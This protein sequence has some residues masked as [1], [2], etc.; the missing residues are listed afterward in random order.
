MVFIKKSLGLFILLWGLLGLCSTPLRPMTQ[1]TIAQS[2]PSA[3][4]KSATTL[5]QQPWV[6]SYFLN[7]NHQP[8]QDF[9]FSLIFVAPYNPTLRALLN[10][11]VLSPTETHLIHNP[12]YFRHLDENLKFFY[13]E[14]LYR[15]TC[16]IVQHQKDFLAQGY[17][18]F[19]H[20]QH[21]QY[22]LF[23]RWYTKLWALKHNTIITDFLFLHVRPHES[24]SAEDQRLHAHL[25][26]NGRTDDYARKHLLFMNYALFANSANHGSNTPHYIIKN[27]NVRPPSLDFKTVFTSIDP[28]W[29][30]LYDTFKKELEA[31]AQKH[32]Q[33]SNY[34]T[35]MLIAIP[36][37]C[38]EQC[39]YLAAGGGYKK[40]LIIAGHGDTENIKLIMKTLSSNPEN[41]SESD[42][43]EFC[44][45]MTNSWGLN[46]HSGIKIIEIPPADPETLQLFEQ[47]EKIVFDKIMRELTR[48]YLS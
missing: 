15:L 33:L 6:Q 35:L 2:A 26:Q 1:R 16:S 47:E 24:N 11:K 18:T 7:N 32:A 20:G 41:S 30:A 27:D 38:I 25:L 17:Y 31:L 28:T 5:A 42:H 37:H 19:V 34:G 13:E 29:N 14:T 40:T 46:P 45:T 48:A 9:L 39:V 12:E 23:E 8:T 21:W 44:L 36:H 22:R 4:I 3:F 10:N 43:L